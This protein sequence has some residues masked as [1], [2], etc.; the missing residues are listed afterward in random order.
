MKKVIF[1]LL[2]ASIAK[3][4]TTQ[5]L[6]TSMDSNRAGKKIGI[7]TGF[8]NPFPSIL[9]MNVNYNVTDWARATAGYGEISVSSGDSKASVTTLG[10]GADAFVP[11]WS[12]SPTAGLRIS[13]VDVSNSG[14]A[15]LE[16]QG[17]EKST[18]LL[19]AQAGLDWQSQG[20]FNIGLG[21]VVGI[22]GGKAAGSYL[23]L[24]W[25]F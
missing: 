4:E 14:G 24:G 2:L 9:G 22:S 1:V 12:L 16:V 7:T 13:K 6:S 3:A 10:A 20:G 19:Y 18:T 15:E 17:V 23:N 25:Y 11:G 8:G 5:S 21:Q